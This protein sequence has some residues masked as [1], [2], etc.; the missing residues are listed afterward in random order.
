MAIIMIDQ[1]AAFDICDH[2]NLEAKIQLMMGLGDGTNINN[3]GPGMHWFHSYLSGRVQYTI[4]EGQISPLLRTPSCSVIQEG[5]G[6]GVQ[7]ISHS[8]IS[9]LENYSNR[10]DE[11][12]N[13]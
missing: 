7:N 11:F 5:C 2:R 1:S 12:M 13:I 10:L 4:L 6:A 3:G 9:H 8:L